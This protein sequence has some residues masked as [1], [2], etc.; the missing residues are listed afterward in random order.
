V[1][2]KFLSPPPKHFIDELVSSGELN[3]EQAELCSRIPLA[4]DIVAEADSGGHTD[5][6]P[7]L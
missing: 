6:R 2:E 3:R 1:A 7:A 5:N 4:Q